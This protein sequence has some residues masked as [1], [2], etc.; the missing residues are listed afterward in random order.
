M[1][2]GTSAPVMGSYVEILTRP[3]QAKEAV[4]IGAVYGDAA[5]GRGEVRRGDMEK[6]GAA[7]AA[8]SWPIIVAKNDDEVVKMI[9]APEPLGS[10]G[11]RV[12]DRPI[13]IAVAGSITPTV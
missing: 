11:I 1:F 9:L 3:H 12:R 8:A 7:P 2:V 5:F 6:D 13:V 10:S 4:K